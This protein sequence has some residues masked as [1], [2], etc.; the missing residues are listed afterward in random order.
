ME[1]GHM[2]TYCA[3]DIFALIE[4]ALLTNAFLCLAHAEL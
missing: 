2:Q 1:V 4:E 3:S